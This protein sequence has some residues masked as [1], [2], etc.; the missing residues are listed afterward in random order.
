M[1]NIILKI[2]SSLIVISI[3]IIIFFFTFP[4]NFIME[5]EICED[6]V[7]KG[8]LG[9]PKSVKTVCTKDYS[10][11]NLV[12]FSMSLWCIAMGGLAF[13]GVGTFLSKRK[14]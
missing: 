8:F 6:I 5:K 10:S 2:S 11:K 12:V 13:W 9:K 3:W 7:I 14:K 1:K 4:S